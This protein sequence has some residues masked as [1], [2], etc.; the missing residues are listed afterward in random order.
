MMNEH[1]EHHDAVLAEILLS[2]IVGVAH[3]RLVGDV[4]SARAQLGMGMQGPV[5]LSLDQRAEIVEVI[6]G[7]EDDYR[8]AWEEVTA[9][10]DI[11]QRIPHL[12]TLERSL[13]A[14]VQGILDVAR[15]NDIEAERFRLE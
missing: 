12:Q 6:L 4:I 11:E 10:V 5:G 9:A 14:A 13:A 7:L 2:K 3:I 1:E 15:Q 8:H